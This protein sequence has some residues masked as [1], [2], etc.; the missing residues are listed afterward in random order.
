VDAALSK[1]LYNHYMKRVVWVGSALRRLRE[2]PEIARQIA[3]RQL[4]RIQQGE[5]PADWRPMPTVG[6]GAIEIRIHRPHEHRVI[7]AA[8]YPEAVYVLA[9][10]EKKTQRTPQKEIELARAAYAE[11]EQERRKITGR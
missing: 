6:T 7:Y 1:N 4:K 10:F 11:I 2:F 9:A 5:E 3:G 8:Q